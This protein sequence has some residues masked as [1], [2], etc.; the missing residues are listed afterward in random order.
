M[1]QNFF[2]VVTTFNKESYESYCNKMLLS[3]D[4]YWPKEISIH[5]YYEDMEKP[6]DNFSS[7][8]IFYNFN[9]N[10]KDWYNFRE[11]FFLKEQNKPDNSVNSFYKYSAIKFA[12]KVYSIKEQLKNNLSDY[13]IWLDSDI[14]TTNNFNI[15]FLKEFISEEYYL[16]YL[17]RDHIK[18]H[19]E[20]GF[21]IFNKSST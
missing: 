2:S 20:C 16:S 13:L 5:V 1:N 17:G 3:F 15:E 11:K 14:I 12:H 8:I 7:R 4:N 10:V 6:S 9:E 18:F 19:S 21:L